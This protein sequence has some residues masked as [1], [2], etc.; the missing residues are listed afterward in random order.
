MDT[1]VKKIQAKDMTLEDLK[2]SA[3]SGIFDP[4]SLP[5]QYPPI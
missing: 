2:A 3:I 4:Q 1:V 5:S